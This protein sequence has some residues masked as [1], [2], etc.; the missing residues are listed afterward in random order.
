MF[1]KINLNVKS[2]NGCYLI[3]GEEVSRQA[4]LCDGHLYFCFMFFFSWYLL[5]VPSVLDWFCFWSKENRFFLKINFY[6]KLW[7][8][9][10]DK[11]LLSIPLSATT[12]RQIVSSHPFLWLTCFKITLS[13]KKKSGKSDQILGVVTK[14]FPD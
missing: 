12:G 9:N 8:D 2:W 7:V 5:W 14:F 1:R 11:G 13:G 6:F 4:M 3:W 10:K